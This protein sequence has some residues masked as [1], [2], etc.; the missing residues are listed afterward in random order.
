MMIT[1]YSH[2]RCM[3]H[4]LK[5]TETQLETQTETQTDTDRDKDTEKDTHRPLTL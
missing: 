5:E 1:M 4:R 2:N 3:W